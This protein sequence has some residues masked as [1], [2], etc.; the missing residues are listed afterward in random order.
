MNGRKFLTADESPVKPILWRLLVQPLP[1]KK[2]YG[3]SAIEITQDAQ[4]AE[5]ILT[6]VGRVIA[7]GAFAYRSKT[8]AGLNLADEPNKPQEG[9]FILFAQYAGQEVILNDEQKT[10]LRIM[11]DS[12][13]LAIVTDPEQIKRYIS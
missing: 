7:M 13:V 6:S 2:T 10:K 9:T 8:N 4:T 1:P 12:E 5:E 3:E 11:D